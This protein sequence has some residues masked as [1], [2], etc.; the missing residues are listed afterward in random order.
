MAQKFNP[1]NLTKKR[2][3]RWWF[4]NPVNSP[5]EVGSWNPI[6]YKVSQ[7]THAGFLNHLT[8]SWLVNTNVCSRWCFYSC[9]F[10]FCAAVPYHNAYCSVW[11]TLL[12]YC[13]VLIHICIDLHCTWH[14]ARHC[15]V[16]I[17][18][19]SVPVDGLSRNAPYQREVVPWTE[20]FGPETRARGVVLW[21]TTPGPGPSPLQATQRPDDE[22]PSRILFWFVCSESISSPWANWHGTSPKANQRGNSN[23]GSI[24][25]LV[26]TPERAIFEGMGADRPHQYG[27]GSWS[28]GRDRRRLGQL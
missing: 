13:L 9:F 12:L 24:A 18:L 8:V 20:R 6:I 5:G 14:I 25:Q 17:V 4:R 23:R 19:F 3:Q 16:V 1:R 7:T 11:C 28:R 27:A 15:C 10:Q 21:G 22:G 2:V 26:Q